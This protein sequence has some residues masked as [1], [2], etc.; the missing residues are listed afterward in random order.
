[1]GV[2]RRKLVR[3]RQPAPAVDPVG[4]LRTPTSVVLSSYGNGPT[5]L[6]GTYPA[7]ALSLAADGP[8]DVVLEIDGTTLRSITYASTR[9]APSRPC[10]RRQPTGRPHARHVA[11]AVA[12]TPGCDRLPCAQ[13][14]IG[15]SSLRNG[16]LPPWSTRGERS[17]CRGASGE[18]GRRSIEKGLSDMSFDGRRSDMREDC[19][20]GRT[21]DKA[22]WVERAAAGEA[23]P[24]ELVG[25]ARQHYWGVTYHTRRFLSIWLAGRTR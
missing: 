25:W 9:T 7:E 1:M 19:S 21:L 5:V 22:D 15:R 14:S 17:R 2:Q 23:T 24:Q 18:L 10:D 3:A 12:R 4:A 6:T 11:G 13:V 8:V 16:R 20:R